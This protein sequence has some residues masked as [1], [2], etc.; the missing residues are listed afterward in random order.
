MHDQHSQRSLQLTPH[1]LGR[2]QR[3]VQAHRTPQAVAHRARLIETWHSHPD[4]NTKQVARALHHH[5][6]WV[7]KWRRRWNE[8]RTLT[9]ATRVR[10]TPSVFIS[11][12]SPD[13]GISV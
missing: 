1:E 12:A 2:L 5:E 11:D 13:N 3:L 8:T 10:G 9:D 4:W 7:R 6:S